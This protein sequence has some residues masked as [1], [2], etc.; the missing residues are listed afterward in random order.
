MELWVRLMCARGI[1]P[2]TVTALIEQFETIDVI[3]AA[4]PE[5]FESIRGKGKVRAALHDPETA[6]SAGERLERLHKLDVKILWRTHP[7]YPSRLARISDPPTLLFVRGELDNTE[8]AA[9]IVGS[10]NPSPEGSEIA[11]DWGAAFARAGI[12]VVSG[13]ARGIDGA[14]HKGALS[15]GGPT[16]AVLGCGPDIAYPPEHEDLAEQILASGGAVISEFWPGTPPDAN[17]FPVRNRTIA[18]LADCTIVVEAAAKSGALL[19]AAEARAQGREV[20]AVPG[21]LSRQTSAGTNMLLQQG[22]QIALAADDIIKH[23]GGR[24]IGAMRNPPP[25]LPDDLA[26]IYA[27]LDREGRHIDWISHRS[28]RPTPEVLSQLLALELRGVIKQL[29]GKRFVRAGD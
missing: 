26:G 29:P 1:G 24:P 16:I 8:Y 10:R 5:A 4:P 14:A 13:M 27:L 23:L 22:A 15:A 17:L 25:K 21:P 6:R 3:F 18:G 11:Y 2:K 9:A 7:E 12:P 20:Y 19:T 28:G